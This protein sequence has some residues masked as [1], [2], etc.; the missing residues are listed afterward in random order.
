MPTSI[1]LQTNP[2]AI[3]TTSSQQESGTSLSAI[4]IL[5]LRVTAIFTMT[6]SFICVVATGT[7]Q[8]L[9]ATIVSSVIT[10]VLIA[11]NF[12]N[13]TDIEP[14]PNLK[15]IQ[16]PPFYRPTSQVGQNLRSAHSIVNLN[17]S[18][19]QKALRGVPSCTLL[20]SNS[21]QIIQK[22]TTRNVSV[23]NF[24]IMPATPK[25]KDSLNFKVP[26]PAMK[27]TNA[28]AHVSATPSK[29]HVQISASPET[30]IATESP[31]NLPEEMNDIFQQNDQRSTA[32]FVS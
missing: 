25:S 8:A 13:K 30:I 23:Q 19:P 32:I 21:V 11:N 22:N 6:I 12:D 4:A 10:I 7:A 9:A 3:T 1:Q 5:A 26:L 31:T 17:N 24:N 20:R 18:I 15:R 16:S 27:T 28:P 2:L 29:R 14:E